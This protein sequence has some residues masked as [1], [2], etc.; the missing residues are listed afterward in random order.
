MS[1]VD[2]AVRVPVKH[3]TIVQLE[4]RGQH[5]LVP[6]KVRVGDV[7][8]GTRVTLPLQRKKEFDTEINMGAEQHIACTNLMILDCCKNKRVFGSK[9]RGEAG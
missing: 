5:V 4:R 2:V 3:V 8:R 1:L 9:L 7:P 6:R